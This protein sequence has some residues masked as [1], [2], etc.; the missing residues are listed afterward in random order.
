MLPMNPTPTCSPLR[1]W[2]WRLSRPA[3]PPAH[4]HC[5]RAGYAVTLTLQHEARG[6]VL[7]GCVAGRHDA[8]AIELV[9]FDRPGAPSRLVSVDVQGCF[10]IDR[11]QPARYRLVLRNWDDAVPLRSVDLRGVFVGA[12]C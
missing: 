7:E 11:L 12:G 6:V 2:L 9:H 4:W 1:Q 5:R 10:R 3:T 8:I